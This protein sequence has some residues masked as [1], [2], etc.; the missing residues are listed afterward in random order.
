MGSP[1]RTTTSASNSSWDSY[2]PF[3]Y[4]YHRRARG[5]TTPPVYSRDFAYADN[6]PVVLMHPMRIEK[7]NISGTSAKTFA[8]YVLSPA[9]HQHHLSL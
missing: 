7:G 1:A 4:S 5:R 8:E 9:H 6:G 3:H 2:N